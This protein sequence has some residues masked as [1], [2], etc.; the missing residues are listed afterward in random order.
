MTTDRGFTITDANTGVI[1]VAS[2]A[3]RLTITGG[4]AATTGNLQKAGAGSLTLNGTYGHTGTTTV[5]A[6]TLNG[7]GTIGGALTVTSTGTFSAGTSNNGASNNGVGQFTAI[8]PR[9]RRQARTRT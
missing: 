2:A 1:D 9:R 6:G 8:A 7:T 5:S 4:S 3:T